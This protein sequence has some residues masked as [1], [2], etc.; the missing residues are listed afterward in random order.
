M[1]SERIL[2]TERLRL[3]PFEAGDAEAVT[4]WC[5]D[6]EL[7]RYLANLPSPYTHADAVHFVTTI[8]NDE[9]APHWAITSVDDG[10]LVGSIGLHPCDPH[11]RAMVGY[12]LGRPFWGKGLM[13]EAL[14]AVIDW[15]FKGTRFERVFAHHDPRNAA[16][17]AVMRKAGMR[18]E[19]RLRSHFTVRGEQRDADFWGILREEHAPPGSDRGPT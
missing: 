10:A 7:R 6:D 14:A 1:E 2:H 15:A 17:G 8:A 4:R 9:N 18:Y 3:R 16:S 5:A 13:T 19:G 12:W 11:R